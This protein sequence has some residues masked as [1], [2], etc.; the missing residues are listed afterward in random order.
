MRF[1]SEVID[2][3]LRLPIGYFETRPVGEMGTRIAELE[4]LKFPT[5]EALSTI[6]DA[7]FSVIQLL[8]Q[9]IAGFLL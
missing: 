8:C 1:G 7:A 6:I 5:G 3:L 9:C 4:K 2:H